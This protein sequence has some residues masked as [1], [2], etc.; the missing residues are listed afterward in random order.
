MFKGMKLSGKIASGFGLITLLGVVVGVVTSVSLNKTIQ[1]AVN[2]E[3]AYKLKQNHLEARMQEKN[4][5]LAKTEESYQAWDAVRQSLEK[6]TTEAQ[7]AVKGEA[8]VWMRNYSKALGSYE[9][10]IKEVHQL[11][12]EGAALDDQMREAARAVEAYLKKKEGSTDALTALLNARRHEKNIVIY[13]DKLYGDKRSAD[14]DK[15]FLQIWQKEMAKIIDSFGS[16]RELARTVADYENLVV[17]R[18]NGLKRLDVI[19]AEVASI[20]LEMVKN[21][22]QILDAAQKEMRSSQAKGKFWTQIFLVAMVFLAATL[23]F[24]LT[25]SIIRPIR[26]VV[27]SLEEGSQQ[28]EASSSEVASASQAMAEGTTQQ[29]ASLEET[30]ASMEEIDAMVRRNAT[31]AEECNRVMLETNEKTKAVHKSL[32]AAR[33]SI[34]L[35]SKSGEEVKKIIKQI[36]EIAFQT[37]LLA[38]NAAVEA[39][40]AGEAGAGFA[41]VAEEVRNLAQRAAG[42][43]QITQELIG[44]TA[45]EIQTGAAQISE[46]LTKFYDMGESAKK[47]NQLVS[48]IAKASEEQALGISQINTAVAQMDK[49]VQSN[50]ASAEEAAAAS[51]QL[52]GQSKLLKASVDELEAFFG[53]RRSNRFSDER[54][55]HELTRSAKPGGLDEPRPLASRQG[56]HLP[57]KA[58]DSMDLLPGE[59]MPINGKS[60]RDF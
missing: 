59:T 56:R 34:G 19:E 60:F 32:R 10:L 21:V 24:F 41:V 52:A 30:A 15:T 54:Q 23:A 8:E 27:L 39:A 9:D 55:L 46:S 5:L 16:D 40:R 2:A 48:D 50:A 45:A 1:E 22:D 18:A 57:A 33:D 42:A 29:A 14:A 3:T 44:Q 6:M 7:K 43:A 26:R 53:K 12:L 38:L 20:V 58:P 47:V 13:G 51:E 4:F 37:N 49:T 25:R 17:K 35:I 36:D 31:N 11:T 28:L